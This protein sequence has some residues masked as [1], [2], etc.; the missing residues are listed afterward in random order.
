MYDSCSTWLSP[1]PTIF[2]SD[3]T[4]ADLGILFY[5]K[6]DTIIDFEKDGAVV[7]ADPKIVG[8]GLSQVKQL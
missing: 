3:R 8:D 2:G 4:A 7:S 6:Y 5:K 1:S